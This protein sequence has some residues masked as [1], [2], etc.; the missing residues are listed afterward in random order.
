MV[1]RK[2]E[3]HLSLF[4]TFT[5]VLLVKT[6]IEP[7]IFSLLG[8]AMSRVSSFLCFFVADTPIGV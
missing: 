1:P 6:D 4:S 5:D 7:V 8:M 2:L 3:H